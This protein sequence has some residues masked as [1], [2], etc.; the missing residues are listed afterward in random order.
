M[1]TPECNPGPCG[2]PAAGR[3]FEVRRGLARNRAQGLPTGCAPVGFRNRRD[4]DGQPYIE[5][6]P[7]LAPL[8]AQAFRLRAEGMPIRAILAE[9]TPMGLVSRNGKPMG[10]SA[11]LAVLR[12]PRCAAL[13]EERAK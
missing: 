9:L 12:N 2:K 11:L 7:A 1:E 6:D 8:V 10:P 3:S 5:E 4:A 13:A